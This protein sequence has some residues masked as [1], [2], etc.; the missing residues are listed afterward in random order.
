LN[1]IGP[2][3]LQTIL[4]ALCAPCGQYFPEFARD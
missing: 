2:K 1:Y 3:K 4:S